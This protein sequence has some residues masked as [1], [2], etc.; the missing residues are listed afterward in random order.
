MSGSA[1]LTAAADGPARRLIGDAGDDREG[2]GRP[3]GHGLGHLRRR[4]QRG[5]APAGRAP[6]SALRRPAHPRGR[7]AVAT[8]PA[9]SGSPRRNAGR[10]RRA[11]SSPG[12]PIVTGGLGLPVPTARG[13]GRPGPPAGRGE[14]RNPGRQRG[15]VILGRAGAVVLA[16]H[17][18]RL[19][20]P[21]RRA[22]SSAGSRRAM[23]I[24]GTDEYTAR[25]RLEETDRARA[26]YVERLYGRDPCRPCA[27]PPD[28]RFDRAQRRRQRRGAGDRGPGLLGLWQTAGN[29]D[30]SWAA[31]NLGYPPGAG[32][33]VS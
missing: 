4:R 32:R 6:R 30:L 29:N 17:P 26:A 13:H 14:H 1:P 8:D 16:D 31:G 9:A 23:A 21:P 3:D 28:P 12:S 25:S 5:G 2:P 18:R 10:P 27:V 19:S 20:R 7:R 11:A 15:A 33:P 24:E 22:P